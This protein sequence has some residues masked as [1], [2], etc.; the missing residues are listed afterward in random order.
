MA[1]FMV[2]N[3]GNM[4]RNKS[5]NVLYADD[6]IDMQQLV[7]LVFQQ[8]GIEVAFSDDGRQALNIWRRNQFD[9]LILDVM[10][11]L[12]D[13]L[14]V[15]RRVRRVSDVPIILLTAKGREQDVVDGFEAGADDYVIKPFR[16][17]ELVARVR[18]IINRIESQ[19]AETRRRLAFESL[20]L[21][22]DARRV[23]HRERNIQVT[24]LEFRLLQY[25]MQH[26]G[27]VLSKE[28]LLQNVWGYD[29]S[30]GDM[31]LIE[32]TVRRL[33]KKL[34]LD[35]SQPRF[36]QTVWGAGYRFGD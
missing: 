10:M 13:G 5:I 17:R 36:I 33:R 25:L 23:I 2:N 21:D 14:E 11:P 28:D 3:N 9:L 24:P 1:D 32:A 6:D 20:V 22:L 12:L 31:N 7:C 19:K 26:A 15:C 30:A 8:A 16:P 18:A 4:G 29:D 34:E 35:P 27:T